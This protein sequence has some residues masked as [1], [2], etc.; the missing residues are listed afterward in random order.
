M[1]LVSGS[2]AFELVIGMVSMLWI[3]RTILVKKNPAPH[4]FKHPMVVP[5]LVWYGSVLLSLIFNEASGKGWGHD[6]A[7]IRYLIYV[8]ALIDISPRQPVFR[9]LLT[10][11]AGGILWG[12]FNIILAHQIG[13]DVFGKPLTRYI[14]KVN[15]VSRI[16]SLAAYAGPFFLG[17]GVL[18]QNISMKNRL[19]LLAIGAIAMFQIFNSHIRTAEFSAIAGILALALYAAK[20]YAGLFVTILLAGLICVSIFGFM[21]FGPR[22]NLDSTYDRIGYWKVTWVMWQQ[23]P[24]LGVS[25]SAWKDAYRKLA[26]SE[27]ITPYISP[28]GRSWQHPKPSHAHNV[29]LQIISSTGI[30]GLVSFGWLLVNC[31]RLTIRKIDLCSHA[32]LSWPVVFFMIGFTGWN[33]Y[34]SQYQTL[35]AYFAALTGVTV[36]AEDKRSLGP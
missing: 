11:M 36:I 24:V 26:A 6:V 17:W 22:M 7:L 5:W 32:I 9:Y 35:F 13:Y 20:K 34:S 18:A 1:G 19:A 16:A 12:L 33:I 21:K 28:D 30:L 2:V 15:E 29:F 8:A 10:G 25:V 4:L 31:I 3:I 27:K 23:N 14:H